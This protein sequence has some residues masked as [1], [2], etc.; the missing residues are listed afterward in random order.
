MA[1]EW[2][3]DSGFWKL[4]CQRDDGGVGRPDSVFCSVFCILPAAYARYAYARERV[5]S[6]CSNPPLERFAL[7][8]HSSVLL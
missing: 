6:V 5:S 4:G 2:M 1:H 3:L 8:C 7:T